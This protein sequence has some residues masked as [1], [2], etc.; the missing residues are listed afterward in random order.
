VTSNVQTSTV[1]DF[2]CHPA[3]R[4][5]ERG[6]R[7]CL[8]TD[9]PG[10]SGIDLPHE[11]EVAAGKAGLDAT[12]TRQAQKHALEMAF[13]SSA[14]KADLVKKKDLATKKVQR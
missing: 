13:L 6:V 1:R 2:A 12:M 8:N 3:K 10:I 9:D 4:L 7:L 14:E 11:Y 5:L